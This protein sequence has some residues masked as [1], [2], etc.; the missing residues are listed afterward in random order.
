MVTFQIFG[1]TFGILILP[2]L[3]YIIPML[4]LWIAAYFE[5]EKNLDVI[6]FTFNM[7]ISFIPILNLI[8][9]IFLVFKLIG[10]LRINQKNKS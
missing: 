8:A 6:E 4:I 9:S 10:Q 7:V 5:I 3:L 2:T 1:E